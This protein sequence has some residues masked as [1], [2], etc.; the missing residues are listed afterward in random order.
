[1]IE[2]V[3]T[4][5]NLA[6]Q[7]IK[8]QKALRPKTIKEPN[9]LKNCNL[10]EK[11]ITKKPVKIKIATSPNPQEGPDDINKNTQLLRV[12]YSG[13]LNKINNKFEC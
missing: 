8:V 5:P 2:Q 3:R 9:K 6:E 10:L 4:L 11:D 1:M 7:G 12:L 13:K